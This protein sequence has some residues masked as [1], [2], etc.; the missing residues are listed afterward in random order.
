VSPPE[1]KLRFQTLALRRELPSDHHELAPVVAPSIT[2]YGPEDR[3]AIELQLALSE[4]PDETR[5][6]TVAR[7]LLPDGV[8]LETLEVDVGRP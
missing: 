1:P 6:T 8:R 5:P 2:S 7:L 3:T 4:L